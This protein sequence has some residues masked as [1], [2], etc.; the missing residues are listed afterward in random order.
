MIAAGVPPLPPPS[1]PNNN[2]NKMKVKYV[3]FCVTLKVATMML[4]C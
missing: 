4:L 2:N 1:L 3:L